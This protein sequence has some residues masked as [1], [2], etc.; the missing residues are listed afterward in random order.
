MVPQYEIY[1]EVFRKEKK[2]IIIFV[3][4][5]PIPRLHQSE[6]VLIRRM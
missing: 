3:L 4:I 5:I 2:M 6:G 1:P